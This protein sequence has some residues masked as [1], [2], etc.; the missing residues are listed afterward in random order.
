VQIVTAR[1]KDRTDLYAKAKTRVT[2][3]GA[4]H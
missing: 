4:D 1:L 2:Q 3:V